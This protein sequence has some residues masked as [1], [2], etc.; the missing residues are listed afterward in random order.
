LHFD[1]WDG[2]LLAEVDAADGTRLTGLVDGE[3][4]LYGDPLLDL[5]SPCLLR[6]IED[7]PEHPFLRGYIA[8]SGEP[9]AVDESVR[10]RLTLYRLHLY[11]IMLI[12]I[13]S[14]GMTGQY[15][16]ARRA[17]LHPLFESEL[18]ALARG[19]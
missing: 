17:R 18:E 16:E 3:R 13:P 1:L 10:R 12:E 8:E 4:Y 9:F 19:S 5:V 6:R 15:A 2:N 7:E 11:L 14:R